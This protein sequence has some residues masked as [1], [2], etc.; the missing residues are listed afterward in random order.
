M[1]AGT[2]GV[3]E[4]GFDLPV[5]GPGNKGPIVSYGLTD[6]KRAIVKIILPINYYF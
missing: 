1:P 2:R 6:G 3:L 5:I 4:L